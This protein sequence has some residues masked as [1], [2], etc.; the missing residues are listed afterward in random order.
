MRGIPSAEEWRRALEEPTPSADPGSSPGDE[1][2]R[3]IFPT[4][5]PETPEKAKTKVRVS[6][7]TRPAAPAMPR[8]KRAA[9]ALILFEYNSAMLTPSAR[10]QLDQL[11]EAL[12]SPGLSTA[13]F[14]IEGHTDAIGGEAYNL[15]LSEERAAAVVNYLVERGID[16][17]RLQ[18][19]GRGEKDL[20]DPRNP[21]APENR[22]V[23]VINLSS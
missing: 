2:T 8:E 4:P 21:T 9:S 3:A 10:E 6:T 18:P 15:K 13:V 7:Q 19:V 1:T 11:A 14:R 16:S 12:S 17:A 22:R 23:K 5:Q 20:Y